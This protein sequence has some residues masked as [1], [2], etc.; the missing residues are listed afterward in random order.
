MK[1]D[2]IQESEQVKSTF[3]TN[4]LLIAFGNAKHKTQVNDK[5]THQLSP[6]DD[7]GIVQVMQGCA[8]LKWHKFTAR[9]RRFGAR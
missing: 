1:K 6:S 8:P 3:A 7:S 9:K 4:N 5:L 2:H